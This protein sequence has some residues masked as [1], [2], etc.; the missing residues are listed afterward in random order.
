MPKKILIIGPAWVG[1]MVMA[2]SLLRL[3]KHR[4][5]SVIID[6]LASAWTFS[7]LSRMPEVSEAIEMPFTHGERKVR[8]RYKL[9]KTLRGRGYD[10]AI[11]LQNSFKAALIPWFAHIPV[12]TGWLGE[13]RYV[14]LNDVRYLNKSGIH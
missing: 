4:D 3:L 9:A 12:R 14:V 1:D 5:P 8:E 11:V 7:L 2:Q 10:Q 13:C 6:V